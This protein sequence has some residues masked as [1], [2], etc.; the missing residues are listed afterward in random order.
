LERINIERL[1]KALHY[2]ESKQ[3][4]L[5]RQDE[6]DIRSFESVIKYLKK[7]MIEQFRLL[8]YDLSIKEEIKNTEVFISTVK[9]IIDNQL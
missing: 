8:D 3:R 4:E 6:K 5:K 7:E 9:N 2:L 1:K